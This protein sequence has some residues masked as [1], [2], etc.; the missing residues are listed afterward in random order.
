MHVFFPNSY[1]SV[2]MFVSAC[3]CMWPCV[4]GFVCSSPCTCMCTITRSNIFIVT[5][6]LTICAYVCRYKETSEGN[7]YWLVSGVVLA[8]MG[9]SCV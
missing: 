7:A 5:Y 4:Y 2:H 6:A 9:R 8:D 1:E 3:A